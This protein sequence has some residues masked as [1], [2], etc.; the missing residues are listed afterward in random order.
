MGFDGLMEQTA[1]PTLKPGSSKARRSRKG[2]R[3]GSDIKDGAITKEE[4]EKH[5]AADEKDAEEHR[6]NVKKEKEAE[7]AKGF[8]GKLWPYTSPR[9]YVYLG[10]LIS[11]IQGI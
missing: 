9:K 8:F 2:S 10:F 4:E 11:M 7:E 5:K 6:F 3:K 1:V